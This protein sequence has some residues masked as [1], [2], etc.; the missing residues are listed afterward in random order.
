ME[1]LFRAGQYVLVNRRAYLQ[2]KPRTGD[3]VVVRDPRQASRLLLKRISSVA[4]EESY[5]VF[6]DNAISSTDSRVFGSVSKDSI[7]GKVIARI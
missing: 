7:V 1:P 6:G 5:F 2:K 4:D 3:V